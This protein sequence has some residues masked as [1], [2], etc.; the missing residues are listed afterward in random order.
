MTNCTE[1]LQ[2]LIDKL[3]LI[4]DYYNKKIIELNED[5]E[6]L[7]AGMDFMEQKIKQIPTS[8]DIPYH[9]EMYIE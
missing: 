1:H 3:S 7:R 6:A 2:K 9:T 5:I 8:T 4:R